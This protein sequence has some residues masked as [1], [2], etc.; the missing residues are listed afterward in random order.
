MAKY[1]HWYDRDKDP[2]KDCSEPILTEQKGYIP[3][4]IQIARLDAAGLQLMASRSQYDW[5]VMKDPTEDWDPTR[6]P[7]YDMADASMALQE[8]E[9]RLRGSRN[10]TVEP[11][12]ENT[13]E[14]E[15][16]TVEE[17]PVSEATTTPE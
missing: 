2:P 11:E 1:K 6:D 3:L 9:E 7:G 8:L 5:D 17:P 16:E 4:H 12:M 14:T 15:S 10:Q 13:T